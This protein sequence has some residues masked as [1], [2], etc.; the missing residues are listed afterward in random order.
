[1]QKVELGRSS[2]LRDLAIVAVFTTIVAVLC[3]RFEFGEAFFSATR[4]WEHLQADELLPV[5]LGLVL[6]LAWFAWRRFGE[7]RRLLL[8]NRRLSQEHVRVQESERRILARELHDELG[9]YLNAIKTDAVLI[10]DRANDDAALQRAATAI[11]QH[12]DHVHGVVRDLIGRLRP[13]GLDELGLEAALE[14]CLDHWQRRLSGV[15]FDV[16]LEGHLDG[17]G[18]STALTVYRLTQEGLTNLA[19]HAG[20][21]SVRIRVARTAADHEERIEFEMTDD[22]CGTD[23]S[24][25]RSGLGLVGMQ[26]R[27]EML[28]GRV[29]FVTEPAKGFSIVAEIPVRSR[30]P[31]GVRS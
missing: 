31:E 9:Q 17:L 28:G 10:Q 22:G 1:M 8:E 30:Q 20:A 18:E 24:A 26:E 2:T 23:L 16:A 3:V 19:A 15:R 27:V 13:V 6:S 5:L 4:R 29:R 14:H 7:A 12:A 11:V 25:R 21:R